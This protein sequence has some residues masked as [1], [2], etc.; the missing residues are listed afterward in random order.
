MKHTVSFST[1]ALLVLT[2]L[3]FS[4]VSA[5]TTAKPVPDAGEADIEG[6]WTLEQFLS[7][8]S[9]KGIPAGVKPPGLTFAADGRLTGFTGVNRLVGAPWNADP[10]TRSLTIGPAATT[11]MMGLSMEAV[12]TENTFLSRLNEVQ[13][14][15][16][17]ASKLLL[18]GGA[19]QVLLVFH[20]A[21]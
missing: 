15:D 19:G 8:G 10:K 6:A 4:L 21:D 7:E 5:C 20:K 2:A 13:T 12:D 3:A 17:A 18:K 14:Y 11:Q 1:S 16:V 9:L